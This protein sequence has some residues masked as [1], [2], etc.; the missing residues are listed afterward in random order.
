MKIKLSD[1]SLDKQMIIKTK[2]FIIVTIITFFAIFAFYIITFYANTAANINKESA[3]MVITAKNFVDFV[4]QDYKT[5]LENLASSNVLSEKKIEEFL[6][7]NTDYSAVIVMNNDGKIINKLTKLSDIRIEDVYDSKIFEKII[8]DKKCLLGYNYDKSSAQIYF[9]QPVM[10]SNEVG[11]VIIGIVK[12]ER[13]IATLNNLSHNEFYT[14]LLL[15]KDG[16]PLFHPLRKFLYAKASYKHIIDKM[17]SKHGSIIGRDPDD[18]MGKYY[19]Y[20]FLNNLPWVVVI[21]LNGKDI[22]MG[23]FN[24]TKE[25]LYIELLLFLWLLNFGYLYLRTLRRDAV[26]IVNEKEF[27]R[28]IVEGAQDGVVTSLEDGKITHFNTNFGLMTG[29]KEHMLLNH[30]IK[31]LIED[32]EEKLNKIMKYNEE[33]E[34]HLK[35]KTGEII[36]V[37]VSGAYLK[38]AHGDISGSFLYFKDIS[39]L[40]NNENNMH[41]YEKNLSKTIDEKNNEIEKLNDIIRVQLR[42]CEDNLESAALE[43]K[44]PLEKIENSLKILKG[45]DELNENIEEISKQLI[46][47]AGVEI[48]LMEFLS[49]NS[50]FKKYTLVDLT[51]IIENAL[52]DLR[53]KYSNTELEIS[54]TPVFPRMFCDSR[55]FERLIET[56]I[57]SCMVLAKEKDKRKIE[58]GW[59]EDRQKNQNIFRIKLDGWGCEIKNKDDLISVF[60]DKTIESDLLKIKKIIEDHKGKIWIDSKKDQKTIFYFSIPISYE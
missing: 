31:E 19:S 32:E 43:I 33:L 16:T 22:I 2:T 34:M 6:T 47:I 21:E 49:Q 52:K 37:L 35:T 26:K 4:L 18:S 29:F 55:G 44:E 59:E 46:R 11:S 53:R 14:M 12:I 5:E 38:D 54:Y 48:K 23:I 60:S 40:K 24:N 1:L 50:N 7:I 57:N 10:V 58:I 30:P 56:L 42:E 20:A 51:K 9:Y 45:E 13:I 41:E 39:K 25:I 27:Y 15:D 3:N 36:P 28:K 17:L 8:K